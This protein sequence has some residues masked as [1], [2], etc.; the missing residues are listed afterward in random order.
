M[1]FKVTILNILRRFYK[2]EPFTIFDGYVDFAAQKAND[3]MAQRLQ[4]GKPL[5]AAKFGSVELGVIGAYEIQKSFG[6]N[7]YFHD[8][9]KGK[10]PDLYNDKILNCLCK[11]AGF[12]PNDV[13]LG[14]KYY[15][16]MQDDM[17]QID[18]LSSYLYEEKYVQQYLNCTRIDL[19]GFYAPFLWTNPWTKVLEGKKVLVVHPF[20][21]SIRYQYENNRTK[22]FD[23]P[24]VLP[25]FKELL[26]VKAVQT[27]ADQKDK[28]FDTW[29]DALDYMKTEIS[30]LDFDIALIGCGAYG[31]CLA[32]HVKR[33]GKQ[34]VHLAGW[35]Q[36]LFGVYGSR[37]LND[38]P[39]YSKLINDY[40]IRPLNSEKPKGLEKVENGCYW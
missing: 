13:S 5:M 33:M 9:M 32:A 22:L 8:Y 2:Q 16:M 23:N 39:Q 28:R 11:N 35:T 34:A 15:Q 10:I 1:D 36:M 38:Q 24:D 14:E 21:D 30:K 4:E 31:M 12:F 19:E 27:I 17:R 18:I 7:D 20:V 26:T 3:L 37:W 25:V 40:W 29:F 6:I